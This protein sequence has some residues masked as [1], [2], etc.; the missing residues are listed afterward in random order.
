MQDIICE[1]LPPRFLC[2]RTIVLA[3]APHTIICRNI[4]LKIHTYFTEKS[5]FLE[6]STQIVRFEVNFILNIV[7]F[8][9]FWKNLIECPDFSVYSA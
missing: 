1:I 3:F 6:F 7:I 8:P 4:Y 2:G 9:I 5:N